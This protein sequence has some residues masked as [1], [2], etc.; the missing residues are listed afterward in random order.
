M[1]KIYNFLIQAEQSE[2]GCNKE[3][4]HDFSYELTQAIRYHKWYAGNKEEHDYYNYTITDDIFEYD[5]TDYIPIGSVEFVQKFYK[6]YHN[7]NNIKPINIPEL[8]NKFEYL[9]RKVWKLEIKDK[10]INAGDK[11]IFVKDNSK[12]KGFTDIVKPNCG[13][14]AG[15]WIISEIVDDIISEWRSFVFNGK[16]VGLQNYSGD[17]LSFPN[18]AIIYDMIYDYKNSPRAYTIDVGI[19]S[20][21]KTFLIEIHHFWSCGLYGF[22]DHRIIPQMFIS[23]HKEILNRKQFL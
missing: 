10:T 21:N 14:P 12:I 1:I 17:F 11:P 3:I 6:K 23:S 5:F 16:L 15:D 22:A 9:Q 20:S 8:L 19:N 4:V 7:I 2:C 13:Y 18:A